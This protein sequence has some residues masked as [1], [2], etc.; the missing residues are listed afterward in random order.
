MGL[1]QI[2]TEDSGRGERSLNPKCF[3]F[4]WGGNVW[5]LPPAFPENSQQQVTWEFLQLLLALSCVESK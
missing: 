2:L 5:T 1:V 3:A 4:G